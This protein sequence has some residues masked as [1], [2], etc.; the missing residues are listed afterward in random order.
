MSRAPVRV[1]IGVLSLPSLARA[2]DAAIGAAL[3]A[4][5]ARALGAA[6]AHDRLREFASRGAVTPE[7]DAGRMKL[8]PLERADRL[9][10]RIATQVAGGLLGPAPARGR[11]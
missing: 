8:R 2:R 1:K 11:R 4:E 9:G 6:H 3:Q 7:L 5:L 10:T